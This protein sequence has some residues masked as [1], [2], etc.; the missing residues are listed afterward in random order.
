MLLKTA[1]FD[2]KKGFKNPKNV[3]LKNS[4][5]AVTGNW[6]RHFLKGNIMTRPYMGLPYIKNAV[7]S[8]QNV[9]LL[10]NKTRIEFL[11][12]RGVD[13]PPPLREKM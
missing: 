2:I 3:P 7:F 11:N 4:Y 6:K 12:G 5:T 13:P 8:L 10:K 1:N 9:P